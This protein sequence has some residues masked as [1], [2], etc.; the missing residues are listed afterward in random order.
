MENDKAPKVIFM[1]G[2]F[3][4]LDVTQEELDELLEIFKDPEKLMEMSEPLDLDKLKEEEPEMYDKLMENFS[5]NEELEA[6]LDG[7]D[8]V[9]EMQKTVDE[10]NKKNYH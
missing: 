1:P 3:D 4:D 5:A 9:E 6:L 10:F 2:C 8:D 7:M